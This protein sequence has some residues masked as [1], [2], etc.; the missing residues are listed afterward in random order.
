[1]GLLNDLQGDIAND[2]ADEIEARA[3]S[4]GIAAEGLHHAVL[5]GFREVTANTGS[6]GR[7]LT[8][9]ILAGPSKGMEVKDTLWTSD[10]EFAQTRMK[11]FAHRLGLLVKVQD[12]AT[13][14]KRYKPVEGKTELL[15]CIGAQVAIEVQH[16]EYETKAG[17]KA[18]GARLTGEGVIELSDK[19]AAAIPRGAVTGTTVPSGGGGALGTGAGVAG[20]MAGAGAARQQTFDDV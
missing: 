8:F 11:I 15:H 6:R 13:G 2:N 12:P 9:K 18:Q 4:G 10:K 3:A 20:V 19:R 1:M 7:E 14:V 16:E 17:K 5:T